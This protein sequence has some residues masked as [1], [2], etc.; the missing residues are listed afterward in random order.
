M[1]EL[2]ALIQL[3]IP[4][5]TPILG[6]LVAFKGLIEFHNSIIEKRQKLR[7][8]QTKVARELIDS[9]RG[10]PLASAALKMLDWNGSIYIRPD[11]TNTLPI[12]HVSRRQQLRTTN[13]VFGSD[14]P[15]AGFIRDCFDRLL[16]DL[17]LVENYIRI[18]LVEFDDIAP[19]FRYYMQKAAVTEEA[20]VLDNFASEYG[21]QSFQDFRQRFTN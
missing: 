16:E 7:W 6:A 1:E 10:N 8:D 3:L 17:N 21:Y 2:K 15:D 18:G 20:K 9:I 12:T 13:T 11:G 14:E 19:F 4:M 5:L